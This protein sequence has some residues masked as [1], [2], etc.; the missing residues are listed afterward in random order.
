MAWSKIKNANNI[1]IPQRSK[2]RESIDIKFSKYLE[3]SIL[4]DHLKHSTG[5]LVKNQSVES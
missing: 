1:V 5:E 4:A 3:I 2:P